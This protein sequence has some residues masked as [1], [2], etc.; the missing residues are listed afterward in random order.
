MPLDHAHLYY[1]CKIAPISEVMELK[2][3]VQKLNRALR[4]KRPVRK[5]C[6]TRA[7]RR[8]LAQV[9]QRLNRIVGACASFSDVH[10]YVGCIMSMCGSI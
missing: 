5:C 8:M 6:R 7:R 1:M 2:D 10:G 4:F 3:S 9:G